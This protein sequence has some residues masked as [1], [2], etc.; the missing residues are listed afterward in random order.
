MMHAAKES[1]DGIV[2]DVVEELCRDKKI[3]TVERTG[4]S[5]FRKLVLIALIMLLLISVTMMVGDNP[6]AS[7]NKDLKLLK[8]L[9]AKSENILSPTLTRTH[10][11]ENGTIA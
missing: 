4:E 10:T 6:F 7:Q 8:Q 11:L 2:T 5:R 9:I 1:P 3:Q